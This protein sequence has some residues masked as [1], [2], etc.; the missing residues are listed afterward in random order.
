VD[1][2]TVDNLVSQDSLKPCGHRRFSAEPIVPDLLDGR[3]QYLLNDV[4]TVLQ[5]QAIVTGDRDQCLRVQLV[6]EASCV[7]ISLSDP[8]NQI[9]ILILY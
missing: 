9:S 5:D 7:F 2:P 3:H 6:K 8:L 1:T 4:L